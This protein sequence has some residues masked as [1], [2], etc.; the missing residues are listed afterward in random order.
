MDISLDL[1][2]RTLSGAGSIVYCPQL[3]ECGDLPKVLGVLPSCSVPT[4][5]RHVRVRVGHSVGQA[6]SKVEGVVD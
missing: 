5:A 2:V 1:R 4:T 6:P 3:Q